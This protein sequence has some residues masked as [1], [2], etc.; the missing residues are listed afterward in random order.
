MEIARGGVQGPREV[1]THRLRDSLARTHTKR[2][3]PRLNG[4]VHVVHIADSCNLVLRAGDG[5]GEQ[6]GVVGEDVVYLDGISQHGILHVL[7]LREH[8]T[9][10]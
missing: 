9:G 2:Q 3:L 10:R 1:H 7:R 4:G 6:V 5:L 8:S